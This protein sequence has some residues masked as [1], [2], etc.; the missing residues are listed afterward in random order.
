MFY[1]IKANLRIAGKI[2]Q[3]HYYIGVNVRRSEVSET[4]LKLL[5]LSTSKKGMIHFIHIP[6]L[7]RSGPLV[8]KVKCHNLH[9]SESGMRQ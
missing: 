6:I 1:R 7:C 4:I 2:G 3:I 5:L 8:R 9:W